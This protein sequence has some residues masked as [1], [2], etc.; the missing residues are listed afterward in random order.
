MLI[1][2]SDAEIKDK[3][4][5]TSETTTSAGNAVSRAALLAALQAMDISSFS[6]VLPIHADLFGIRRGSGRTPR[7]IARSNDGGMAAVALP[8]FFGGRIRSG[9]A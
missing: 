1:Q 2:K 4:D 7:R 5:A 8:S 3:A 6:A 9:A